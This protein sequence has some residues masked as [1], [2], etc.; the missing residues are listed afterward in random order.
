[1]NKTFCFAI[2]SSVASGFVKCSPRLATIFLDR[3]Q[4]FEIARE[5]LVRLHAILQ[6]L[7]VRLQF[8]GAFLRQRIDHP[9]LVPLHL[10]HSAIAKISEVLGNFY[11]W[12]A[13]DRLEMADAQGRL[14]QQMENPQPRPVAETLIDLNQIHRRQQQAA[15]VSQQVS[16]LPVFRRSW[17]R[18]CVCRLPRITSSCSPD[19][20][21][22]VIGYCATTQQSYSTS[23][24]N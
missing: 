18:H 10:P 23:T 2:S 13:Q 21:T 11:L 19:R 7:Q 5:N 20:F 4:L 16:V 12:L 3:C 17:A 14:R 22:S 6:A 1:M 9:V 15:S 8:R 24:S